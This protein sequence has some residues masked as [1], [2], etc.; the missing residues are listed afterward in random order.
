MGCL[1]STIEPFNDLPTEIISEL[2]ARALEL[3]LPAGKVIFRQGDPGDCLYIV[4]EGTV[5]VYTESEDHVDRQLT[6]LERGAVFGE[7]ALLTGQPRSA[8]VRTATAVRL[9]AI[10]KTDFDRL[11]TFHPELVVA[12]ARTLSQRLNRATVDLSRAEA[13]EK[14][15]RYLLSEYYAGPQV[16]LVGRTK[17]MTEVIARAE[18]LSAGSEPVLVGGPPGTEKRAVAWKIHQASGRGGGP[19]V[20]FDPHQAQLGEA[21][22]VQS[23]MVSELAQDAILF[24]CPPAMLPSMKSGRMGLLQA[25]DGGTVVIENI[26]KLEPDVQYKLAGYLETGTFLLLDGQKRRST[27]RVIGILSGDTDSSC[28]P[29]SCRPLLQAFAQNLIS[30]PALARRKKDLGL[31]LNAM[32][33]SL[34][35]RLGKRI[36]GVEQEAYQAVLAYDWPGNVEELEIVIRRAIKLAESDQIRAQDIFIGADQE[37]GPAV[38]LLKQPPLKTLF[39]SPYF[40][41][42]LQ[43]LTGLS[44]V[45]VLLFCVTGFWSAGTNLALL[46]VWGIGEP[47]FLISTVG[48]ARLGC[49]FCPFGR[50]SSILSSRGLRR[51]PPNWLRR[52]G[53]NFAALG[54]AIILWAEVAT[55]M[56]HS[57]RPTAVLI[58]SILTLAMLVGLVFKRRTWCRFLCPLGNW[59]GSLATCSALELRGKTAVCNSECSSHVCYRGAEG[60]GGCPMFEGPFSLSQNSDCILCGDCIKVCPNNSPLIN[61]RLPAQELWNSRKPSAALSVFIP[62]MVTTQLLRLSDH[63]G[64]LGSVKS[65]HASGLV[66]AVLTLAFWAA[67]LALATGLSTIGSRS[68]DGESGGAELVGPWSWITSGTALL[69]GITPLVVACEIAY[70]LRALLGRG[71]EALGILGHL[72]GWDQMAAIIFLPWQVKAVQLVALTA[73]TGLT[74]MVEKKAMNRRLRTPGIVGLLFLYFLFVGLVLLG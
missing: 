42:V 6:L 5:S 71:P 66:L 37:A 34:G 65:L 68:Q 69:V 16:P 30:I 9:M 10:R 39:L 52:Y 55:G 22:K 70:Q 35:K 12:L 59:V 20:V 58:L 13:S 43:A 73:G 60:Q 47:L 74:L 48:T 46:A 38:E 11:V 67:T 63:A 57:P 2:A 33:E 56:P 61:L 72:L 31:I 15:Y 51:D 53:T 8:S 17:A 24:G 28:P 19:F 50:V 45:A 29:L 41:S 49:S 40:P 32:V 54:L 21:R 36:N 62:V 14:A 64:L 4:T 26:D 27:G 7:M 18:Q 44:L 25:A 3:D 1:L 23:A